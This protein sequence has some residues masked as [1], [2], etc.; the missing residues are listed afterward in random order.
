MIISVA[1]P[2][3]LGRSEA[4]L[5]RDQIVAALDQ[6]ESISIDAEKLGTLPGLWLQ[7]L[8]AAASSAEQRGQQLIL[9]RPSQACLESFAEL[10]IDPLAAHMV[11]EA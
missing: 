6:G 3:Q 5:V 4:A 9:R 1:L 10:G 8:L 11:L 2:A 7:L